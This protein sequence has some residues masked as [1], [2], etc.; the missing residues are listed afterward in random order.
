MNSQRAGSRASLILLTTVFAAC[1][2]TPGS[3]IPSA[4]SPSPSRAVVAT[5]TPSAT[6]SPSV[7]PSSP[8]LP[9]PEPTTEEPPPEP[10]LE[11]PPA[12]SLSVE[13]G[14]PVVGELGSFGWKNGASDSPWLPGYPIR[15]GLGERLTLTMAEP[16]E[17]SEWSVE[18]TPAATF[19]RD[20]IVGMSQGI[21]EP[22]SFPAPPA[23]SWSVHVGLLFAKGGS[24]A[25]FWQIDVE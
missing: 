21:G 4:G 12:A 9:S 22:V 8:A 23:G 17:I 11:E 5:A 10:P 1:S 2:A 19:G 3:T 15:V 16:V 25:Y 20:P 6:A 24:A 7:E 13:G 18:R 14:D